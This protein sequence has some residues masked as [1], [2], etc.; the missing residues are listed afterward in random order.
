MGNFQLQDSQ[1][2]PYAV[3]ESDADGTIGKPGAGDSVVIASSDAASMI[4]APDAAVDPAKVPNNADGTPGDPTKC[5]QTGFLV[6][7]KKAQ[8]GVQATATFAH[9]DGTPA[10]APVVDLIDIIVGPLTTGA[11]SLGTPVAQ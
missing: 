10:P 3:F 2:V 4:V 11:I 9:S 8:V 5:L 1:K 7:G 6:G